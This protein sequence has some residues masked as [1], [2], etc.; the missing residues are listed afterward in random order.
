MAIF[1]H[2]D[3]DSKF[4]KVDYVMNL[5]H[6]TIPENPEATARLKELY[7]EGMG[8]FGSGIISGKLPAGRILH[9]EMTLE[10]A[11]N[12]HF[13]ERPSR[14]ACVFACR[15][16]DD[17]HRLRSGLF[18]DGY[19]WKRARIWKVEATSWFSADLNSF[20]HWDDENPE[21]SARAYWSGEF[22]PDPFVECLLKPPVK[23]L[24]EVIYLPHESSEDAAIRV[25]RTFRRLD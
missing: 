13:A 8:I 17:A 25:P 2:V 22:S 5:K 21:R 7:P 23:I 6:L 15:S 11:R 19:D 10:D 18:Q 12:R 4:L 3:R 9:R 1:Y 14:F 20:A 16:I 24:E